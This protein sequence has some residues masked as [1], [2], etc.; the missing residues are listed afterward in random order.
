MLLFS[1]ESAVHVVMFC[2][3]SAAEEIREFSFARWSTAVSSAGNKLHDHLTCSQRKQL[4]VMLLRCETT[5][6][7]LMTE[8]LK[9][10]MILAMHIPNPKII[11]YK[12]VKQ[13][14]Y[15]VYISE[16]WINI[17]SSVQFNLV[18]I[19]TQGPDMNKLYL[20]YS[21]LIYWVIID[22]KGKIQNIKSWVVHL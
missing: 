11:I 10:N 12:K 6:P 16:C 1:S 2:T 5:G 8:K 15:T 4:N 9:S 22:V 14:H 18:K 20:K 17:T 13:Y 3:F 21:V 7:L 19:L